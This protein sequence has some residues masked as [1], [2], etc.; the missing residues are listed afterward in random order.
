MA[1][2][3]GTVPVE[4]PPERDE[5]VNVPGPDIVPFVGVAEDVGSVV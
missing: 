2:P 4:K 5:D 1:L 3:A